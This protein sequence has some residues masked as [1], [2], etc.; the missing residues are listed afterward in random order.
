MKLSVV[1][2]CYNEKDSLEEFYDS[3]IKKMIEEKIS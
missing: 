3:L 1:V 2:P